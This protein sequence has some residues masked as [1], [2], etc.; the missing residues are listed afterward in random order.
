[1]VMDAV[2]V[3][4]GPVDLATVVAIG[5]DGVAVLVAIGLDGVAVVVAIGPRLPPAVSRASGDPGR[6]HPGPHGRQRCASTQSLGPES[7]C[8]RAE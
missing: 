4:I 3:M 1:M 2:V 5:L 6:P 8:F 7:G